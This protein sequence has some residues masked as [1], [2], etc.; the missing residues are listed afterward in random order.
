MEIGRATAV[1]GSASFFGLLSVVPKLIAIVKDM[2]VASYF[3]VS[4]AVDTYSMAIVLIGFPVSVIIVAMQTTLIPALV[5]KSK[6]AAACLLSSTVKLAFLLLLIA[7][8]FWLLALPQLLNILYPNSKYIT[9]YN[10]RNAC[11]WL[12]P[13]YLANGINILFYGALQA[14]KIFWPNALLPGL[15]PLS[16][17]ITICIWSNPDI[18]VLLIGT[19]AGSILEGVALY[20]FLKKHHLL[21]WYGTITSDLVKLFKLT[22]PLIVSGIVTALSPLVEQLIAFRLGEGAVSVLYYGSKVPAAINSLIVTAIGIV[23]LPHFAELITKGE[24][25]ICRE[26][27]LRLCIVFFFL[28]LL[29]SFIF[30]L[31]AQPIVRILFERGAFNAVHTD[32]TVSIMRVYLIQLPFVLI[33]ILS[34]RVLAAFKSTFKMAFITSL[35]L[36]LSSILAYFFSTKIGVTGVGLGMTIGSFIAGSLFWLESFQSF[37]KA[38]M[39]I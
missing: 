36:V 5:E 34:L 30:I 17:I 8:P 27:Y 39:E 20:L 12:I 1:L 16:I 32:A 9:L 29:I 26:L 37:Y 14:R 15:F 35:Q 24:F 4:E 7:L 6:D 21:S 18:R 23:V 33:I 3:G 22:I 19:T 2:V 28:G 10:L 25:K 13:Y 31:F 38:T 11:F